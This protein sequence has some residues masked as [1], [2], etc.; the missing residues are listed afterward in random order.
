[1]IIGLL[2]SLFVLPGLGH[3]YLKRKIT[4]YIISLLV[5]CIALALILVFEWELLRQARM[6]PDP[7]MIFPSLFKLVKSAWLVH[8]PLHLAGLGFLGVIWIYAAWD[9][10]RKEKTQQR[11][12]RQS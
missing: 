10:V 12:S 4:G 3:L 7:Q 11:E 2:L 8:R 5:C 1:M 6:L 9:L